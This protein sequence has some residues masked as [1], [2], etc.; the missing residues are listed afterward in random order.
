LD[1][2]ENIFGDNHYLTA[3]VHN[4]LGICYRNLGRFENA[5]LHEQKAEEARRLF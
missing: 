4:T 5:A 3:N 2:L 1:I